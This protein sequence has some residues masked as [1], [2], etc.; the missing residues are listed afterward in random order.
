MKCATAVGILTILTSI[1]TLWTTGSSSF[2]DGSP[3]P[4]EASSADVASLLEHGRARV[5]FCDERALPVDRCQALASAISTRSTINLAPSK[6]VDSRQD[7]TF[8][9]FGRD[10]PPRTNSIA[11]SPLTLYDLEVNRRVA[12]AFGPFSVFDLSSQYPQW[13]A[14]S[15]L[16]AKGFTPR[17]DNYDAGKSYPWVAAYFVPNAAPC[18]GHEIAVLFAGDIGQ[19]SSL[20]HHVEVAVWEG[21][22]LLISFEGELGAG[23]PIYVSVFAVNPDASQYATQSKALNTILGFVVDEPR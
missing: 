9:T 21:S 18:K 17:G 15:L 10:C 4:T 16:L 5:E 19:P 6:I 12:S 23:L 8:Q 20:L 7:D 11:G 2:A 3:G 1:G 14:A 13:K 22:V